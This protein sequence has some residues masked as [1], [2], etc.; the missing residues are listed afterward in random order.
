MTGYTKLFSTIVTSTIWQED[1]P[2][3][4][5]WITL[6]ALSDSDGMVEG[7][8]PGLARIA[9]V[10]LE[11][12]ERSLATLQQ[13][14]RYSRTPD[15]DGRRIEAVEGGWFILNRAKYRDMMPDERRRERN[16]LRQQRHRQGR[17]AGSVT[18][19]RVTECDSHDLS[20]QKEKEKEKNKIQT[21]SSELKTSSDQATDFSDSQSKETA[22]PKATDREAEKLAALLS[23]EIRKN[24]PDFRITPAQQRK[25]A[26]IADLML[27][28]DHRSYDEIASVIHWCQA[29]EFWRSNVLSFGKLREKFDQLAMKAQFDGSE[30]QGRVSAGAARSERSKRNI[31]EGM[32]AAICQ[33]ERNAREAAVG[34]SPEASKPPEPVGICEACGKTACFKANTTHPVCGGCV[35][36]TH[37]CESCN[38]LTSEHRTRCFECANGSQSARTR[39]SVEAALG[40]GS[41]EAV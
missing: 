35:G 25:W 39:E 15:N 34:G 31:L 10:S 29:D 28:R 1:L 3:K 30:N 7:S 23:G 6:L 36:R 18:V 5:L 41:L 17:D 8:V 13:P 24:A 27:R 32:M 11:E 38:R 40:R 33:D 19:S 20:H 4:V 9:G 2:T 37:P 14:D 26:A 16:R 22:S 21:S 12:C